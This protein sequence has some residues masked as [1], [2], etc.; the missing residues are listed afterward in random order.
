[1]RKPSQERALDIVRQ[2]WEQGGRTQAVS[3]T[4]GF[5]RDAVA[6]GLLLL[7][8]V[9]FGQGLLANR[10]EHRDD[11]ADTGA[12]VVPAQRAESHGGGASLHGA[13]GASAGQGAA[14][15]KCGADQG[16]IP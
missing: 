10:E 15:M 14:T 2:Q 12:V 6:I 1:M 4:G 7:G 8:V 5:V 3:P 9:V 11:G 16:C 13:H